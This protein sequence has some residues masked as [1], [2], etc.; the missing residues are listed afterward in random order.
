VLLTTGIH[1]R[2]TYLKCLIASAF[3]AY[4]AEIEQCRT[5]SPQL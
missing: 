2:F 4:Y 5:W 3:L 1:T